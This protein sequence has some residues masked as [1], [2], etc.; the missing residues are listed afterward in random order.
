MYTMNRLLI[1]GPINEKT[2]L[3]VIKEIADSHGIKYDQNEYNTIDLSYKLRNC[4]ETTKIQT[5]TEIKD[6]LR[7]IARYVNKFI[8][9]PMS[10]LLLAY[11][12]LNKFIDVDDPLK[13]IP[14]NFEIGLQTPNN[15]ESI[16]ACILYKIC[17]VHKINLTNL[18]TIEEMKFAVEMVRESTESLLDRVRDF[19]DKGTDRNN[20][21]NILLL[22]NNNHE[23][24]N[25]LRFE[26]SHNMLKNVHDSLN[27]IRFLQKNINPTNNQSA[28]SLAA[29]NYDID[30]S[31]SELPIKEYRNLKLLGRTDYIPSDTWMKQWYTKNPSIFDLT[32]FFNP[33]F[34]SSYYTIGDLTAMAINQGYKEEDVNRDQPYELLQLAYVSET[35]Y[36][37]EMPNLKIKETPILLLNINEIPYGQLLSY[38]SCETSMNPISIE[39]LIELFLINENFSNPFSTNTVISKLAI[40]KLKIMMQN[41]IG[42]I[43]NMQLS[44]DTIKLRKKLHETIIKIENS[45]KYKDEDTRQLCSVYRNSDPETK[46]LIFKTLSNLLYIGMY[47]RGWS[48]MGEYPVSLAYVPIEKTN[49]VAIN[50]T[51][52][53]NEYENLVRRLGRIGT[54]I[55]NLPLVIY[56]D[57]EYHISNSTNEGLTINDRIKIVKDGDNTSNTASC[58]RL[59]SNWICSSAHKYI[60]ALGL[61]PPFDIFY[62][63]HIS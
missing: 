61:P 2:P 48:G 10:K 28:I 53:I 60:I 26:I 41:Q 43:P 47:M 1:T 20:L 33:L 55:N 5:I 34:P 32:I 62:L 23:K 50:V 59:S 25:L 15:I 54:Q 17:V 58:I 3:C 19:I 36:Y 4:I 37:G 14:I 42:H 22:S 11:D 27:N 44:D 12:F 46:N 24:T 57:K 21:I 30:I 49:E 31:K 38:G 18:T 8:P 35:F 40:N 13:I 7:D 56:K 29:I 16:N 63:R 51:N 9:W 6:N 52:S 39:E 45:F